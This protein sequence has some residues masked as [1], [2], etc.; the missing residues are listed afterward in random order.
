MTKRVANQIKK[1]YGVDVATITT[2]EELV[3]AFEKFTD[4]VVMD[5]DLCDD[6]M[7][8]IEMVDGALIVFIT[9]DEHK[10][11]YIYME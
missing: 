7:H 4:K 9:D 1:E 5:A 3:V 8:Y 10:L 6:T 2:V 11:V